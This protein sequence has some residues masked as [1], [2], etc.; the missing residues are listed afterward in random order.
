M[1]SSVSLLILGGGNPNWSG[2][3]HLQIAPVG[4]RRAA[5]GGQSGSASWQM[6]TATS[7]RGFGAAEICRTPLQ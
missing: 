4:Q 5:F 3:H 6:M 1:G 2:I 7:P